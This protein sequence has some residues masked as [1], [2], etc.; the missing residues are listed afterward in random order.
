MGCE[1]IK[2]EIQP[3]AGEDG[4]AGGSELLAQR[5]DKGMSSVLSSGSQ[6][7]YRDE[8]AEGVDRRPQPEDTSP[9]T[10]P[11]AQFVQLDMREGAVLQ[12]CALLKSS[13][14][15]GGDSPRVLPTYAPGRRHIQAFT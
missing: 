3:I 6:L 2:V 7:E 14:Q 5:V 11:S 13:S 15:P 9:A 12:P 4:E 8:L 10:Q 1:C